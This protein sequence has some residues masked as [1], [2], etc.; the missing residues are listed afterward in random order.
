MISLV[1]L[2]SFSSSLPQWSFWG[3]KKEREHGGEEVQ[4]K[5]IQLLQA[6]YQ[7]FFFLFLFVCLF[8]F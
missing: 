1:L 3:K 8:A 5:H 6:V 7:E 2:N 4:D